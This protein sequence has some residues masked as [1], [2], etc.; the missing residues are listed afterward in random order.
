[1]TRS[2]PGA[3]TG[4]TPSATSPSSTTTSTTSWPRSTRCSPSRR[5]PGRPRL[6]RRRRPHPRRHR[7]PARAARPTTSSSASRRSP[8]ATAGRRRPRAG[9]TGCASAIG[10]RPRRPDPQRQQHRGRAR[11]G[12]V[13]TGL[14]ERRRRELQPRPERPA[15]DA[16]L[17]VRRRRRLGG[18][19]ALPLLEPP[20]ALRRLPPRAPTRA[21]APR[22][23]CSRPSPAPPA[24]PLGP[25]NQLAT[26][27]GGTALRGVRRAT[28]RHGEEAGLERRAGRRARP[29]DRRAG[30]QQHRA[31]RR[32]RH[33]VLVDPARAGR[34]P[35]PRRRAHEHSRRPGCAAPT[36]RSVRGRGC[37]ARPPAQRRP[38]LLDRRRRHPRPPG[39]QRRVTPG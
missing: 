39:D 25:P 30:Q 23:R 9:P 34:R 7:A 24:P 15:G 4:P 16:G 13:G 26:F 1:M 21:T 6:G 10:G 31:R 11:A 35:D 29:R 32:P 12:L 27:A 36:S 20:R 8:T 19:R 18:H 14:L 37:L 3:S 33:A 2:R 38:A 5:D 22:T 28:R 17:P